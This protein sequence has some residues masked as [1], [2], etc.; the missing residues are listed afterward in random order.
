MIEVMILGTGG[1]ANGELPFNSWMLG[2]DTLVDV[3]PDILQSL[4][5]EKVKPASLRT[6]ILTHFHGDH[7]FGLPFLLFAM[8]R[9]GA[10]APLFIGP[11][12]LRDRVRSLMVS[13]IS[14]ES[15]YIGWFDRGARL[16][17]IGDGSRIALGD[18]WISFGRMD[19]PVPTFGM[20]VGAEGGDT[21]RF[22]A[23]ADTR[24]G[25]EAASIIASGARIA[26]CDSG[27]SWSPPS[28]H[29]SAEELAREAPALVAEGT[30]IIG[31]H[32]SRKP[33]VERMG[34]V[35]FARPGDRFLA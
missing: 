22:A 2:A 13:A 14:S 18:M 5:R 35:E 6:I 31:T 19:H 24:W 17:E 32:L 26:L 29:M 3:P 15:A 7:C 28:I 21:P 12:G 16:V 8:H 23:T 4:A 33:P 30:R 20:L 1:F 27:G 10:P 11:E 25:P 9:D 34:I